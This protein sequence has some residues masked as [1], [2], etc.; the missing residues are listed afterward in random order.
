MGISHSGNRGQ[1]EEAAHGMTAS[2]ANGT[3][4][5]RKKRAKSA[6][7]V[8]ISV[9]FLTVLYNCRILMYFVQQCL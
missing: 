3:S 2:A 8:S 9:L 5:R 6:R 1:V 4:K 7:H